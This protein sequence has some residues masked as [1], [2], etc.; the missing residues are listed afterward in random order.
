[1]DVLYG[2]II[3]YF[4][5]F[6]TF[7]SIGKRNEKYLYHFDL[8]VLTNLKCDLYGIFFIFVVDF[9]LFNP[10]LGNHLFE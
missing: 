4:W 2:K 10:D 9:Y 3:F 1:M 7:L 6:P 5:P 8:V